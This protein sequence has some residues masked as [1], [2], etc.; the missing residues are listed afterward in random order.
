[1]DLRVPVRNVELA[2]TQ[3]HA[4]AQPGGSR[5]VRDHEFLPA[6]CVVCYAQHETLGEQDLRTGDQ[7]Q[8]GLV[9]GGHLVLDHFAR[10][11]IDDHRGVGIHISEVPALQ[12]LHHQ[13]E[14]ERGMFELVGD[15]QLHL[16]RQLLALIGERG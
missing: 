5:F 13:A 10:G 12:L 7:M 8:D 16:Q 9:Q 1:M 11:G 14:A 15:T 4:E 2:H 3:A 6:A